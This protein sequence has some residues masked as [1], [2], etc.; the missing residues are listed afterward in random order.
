MSLP[1]NMAYLINVFVNRFSLNSNKVRSRLLNKGENINPTIMN[2][3][4]LKKLLFQKM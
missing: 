3:K 4:D 2:L 1:I